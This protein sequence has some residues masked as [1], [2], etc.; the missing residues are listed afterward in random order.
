M[1]VRI[2]IKRQNVPKSVLIK[3]FFRQYNIY[4]YLFLEFVVL[5]LFLA[6]HEP[7]SAF[8]AYWDALIRMV[9]FV[10]INTLILWCANLQIWIQNDNFR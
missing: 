5:F 9:H 1:M 7:A 10:I 6:L 4:A 2:P 8:F 3:I